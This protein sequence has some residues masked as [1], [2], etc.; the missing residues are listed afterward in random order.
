[1]VDIHNHVLPCV[2]DGAS[3]MEIAVEMCQIAHRDGIT[4]LV[5]T[6]HA[7]F[8]YNYDREAHLLRLAELQRQVPEINLILGCDLQLSFENFK[9]AIANP[10]RYSI[11][12]TRYVLIE[13][14]DFGVPRSVLNSLFQMHSAGIITIVTHPERIMLLRGRFDLLEEL[15]NLGSMLQITA[16]SLTG[17]WGEEVQRSAE[18]MLRKGLVHI[19]ASDA[20][21]PKRRTPVLSKA[22]AVAAAMVGEEAANRLVSDY[23]S[24]VIADQPIEIER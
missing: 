4:H 23:P 21:D 11:G 16:N 19:I 7:N 2:D 20:H 14:S 12:D 10:K 18:K 3:S 9:D 8:T 6:P 22:R 13:F 17:F 1:M 5:A 24:M 15:V